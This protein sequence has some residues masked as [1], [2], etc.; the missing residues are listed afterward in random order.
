MEDR[1]KCAHC[2]EEFLPRTKA[3]KYCSPACRTLACSFRASV[4][5]MLAR[6]VKSQPQRIC[7]EC[8]KKYTPNKS[9]Q[10]YCSSSCRAIEARKSQ[11]RRQEE[12]LRNGT[13]SNWLKLRFK[14]L[15]RDNFT[16]QYCGRTP[17]DGAKLH[18]DHIHPKSKGGLWMIDNLTTACFECNEGKKDTILSERAKRG[19]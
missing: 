10:K 15:M 16:C 8:G 18:I 7:V 14:V 9:Y 12:H 3:Y 1:K 11:K 17:K 5:R 6:H 4:K 2:D 13:D 19:L